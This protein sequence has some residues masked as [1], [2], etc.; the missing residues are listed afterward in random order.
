MLLCYLTFLKSQDIYDFH[1]I[2]QYYYKKKQPTKKVQ[3]KNK[4]PQKK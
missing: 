2:I 1:K 4:I 3:N